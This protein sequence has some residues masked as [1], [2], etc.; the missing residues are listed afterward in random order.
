M[1]GCAAD[2]AASGLAVATDGSWAER[3]EGRGV[4]GL[5]LDV[6]PRRRRAVDDRL[7]FDLGSDRPVAQ[8]R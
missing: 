2:G 4:A 8:G 7:R 3:G 1:I 6:K 5:Q